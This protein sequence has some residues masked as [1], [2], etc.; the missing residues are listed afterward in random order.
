V[1]TLP[2]WPNWVPHRQALAALHLL[3]HTTDRSLAELEA[4]DR[5]VLL[6]KGSASSRYLRQV[7]DLL[8]Q[9]LPR[10]TVVELPGGHAS[11]IESRE[12][13][14]FGNS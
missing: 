2:Q 8:G 10:A 1:R 11:H 7:V 5:P 3:G 9:R 6:I 13:F 14:L 4:F 12:I